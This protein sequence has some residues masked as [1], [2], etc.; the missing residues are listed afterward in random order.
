MAII[1]KDVLNLLNHYLSQ[2]GERRRF[3]ICG[4]ASLVL[5]G[6]DGRET[7]DID[8]VGPA[9]DATLNEV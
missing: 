2:K 1:I 3:V 6:V 5:Q 9:I 4:G 7:A 8:I